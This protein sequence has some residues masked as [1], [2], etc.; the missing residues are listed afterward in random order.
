MRP[1]AWKSQ[2]SRI[3][4]SRLLTYLG[5][6]ILSSTDRQDTLNGT[7]GIVTDSAFRTRKLSNLGHVLTTFTNAGGSFSTGDDSTN[8]YPLCLV[9]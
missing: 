1:N 6:S 4:K 2:Q 7:T 3:S 8:M 9:L 5:D